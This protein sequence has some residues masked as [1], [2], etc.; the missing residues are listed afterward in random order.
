MKIV[1]QGPMQRK[2]ILMPLGMI[3]TVNGIARKNNISFAEVVRIETVI[4]VPQ[5]TSQISHKPE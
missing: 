1:K 4:E 2:P 3:E 5:Y